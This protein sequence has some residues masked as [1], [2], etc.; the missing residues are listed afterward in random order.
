MT[1]IFETCIDNDVLNKDLNHI[2]LIGNQDIANAVDVT[3]RKVCDLH[4]QDLLSIDRLHKHFELSE[5]EMVVFNKDPAKVTGLLVSVQEIP[6]G[7]IP[8]SFGYLRGKLLIT[9]VMH[10]DCV[11]HFSKVQAMFAELQNRAEIFH[12]L[13]QFLQ[14]SSFDNLIGF[15]LRLDKILSVE[16][17]KY[18]LMESTYTDRTQSIALVEG[19]VPPQQN[20]AITGWS[21]DGFHQE[22]RGPSMRACSRYCEWGPF[23][24]H[25]CYHQT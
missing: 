25:V 12:E 2:D 19:E 15:S 20:V 9:S 14:V 16:S 6:A 21:T 1:A 23:K 7:A 17:N 5:G 18:H 3:L 4:L 8:V 24:G 11:P 10:P 22:L 13:L